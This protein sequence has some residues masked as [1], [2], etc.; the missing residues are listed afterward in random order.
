MFSVSTSALPGAL[1]RFSTVFHSPLFTPSATMRELQAVDSE[2]KK[3]EQNDTW[4]VYQV[5]KSLSRAGHKWSKFGN[6]NMKSLTEVGKKLETSDASDAE[7][8][9][10]RVLATLKMRT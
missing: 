3:N 10:G 5:M 6:G 1:D 7:L 4:R 2:H 9:V 8:E